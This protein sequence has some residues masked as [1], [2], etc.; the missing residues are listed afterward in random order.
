MPVKVI[1]IK[2]AKFPW[3]LKKRGFYYQTDKVI[4]KDKLC[5][6]KIE[7]IEDL[8]WNLR[9]KNKP[10]CDESSTDAEELHKN[11]LFRKKFGKI[12]NN[13]I[14]RLIGFNLVKYQ[15]DP[16]MIGITLRAN[17]QGASFK[18]IKY[19]LKKLK[20]Y[21][22]AE[23]NAIKTIVHHTKAKYINVMQNA[24]EKVNSDL[25]ENGK[26]TSVH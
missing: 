24:L 25:N 14:I 8:Y 13:D 18:A 17:K 16:Q 12:I 19:Y 10:L 7:R 9:N 4:L 6:P 21:S 20:T 26:R 23:Q 5:I 3:M 22:E 2:K 11:E 15:L 1:K